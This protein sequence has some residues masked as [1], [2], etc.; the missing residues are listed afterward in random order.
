[1]DALPGSIR[2]GSALSRGTHD[3]AGPW[4]CVAASLTPSDPRARRRERWA[5]RRRAPGHAAAMGAADTALQRLRVAARAPEAAA[6]ARRPLA[7]PR[8]RRRGPGHPRWPTSDSTDSGPCRACRLLLRVGRRAT[9]LRTIGPWV[10]VL[11]GGGL[12]SAPAHVRPSRA[13]GGAGGVCRAR[14]WLWKRLGREGGGTPAVCPIPLESRHGGA[15]VIRDGRTDLAEDGQDQGHI[16]GREPVRAA[17]CTEEAVA[18]ASAAC[19]D[20]V[21][22]AAFAHVTHPAGACGD[23]EGPNLDRWGSCGTPLNV[24]KRSPMS[25]DSGRAVLPVWPIPGAV[26]WSACGAMWPRRGSYDPM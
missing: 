15:L 8:P 6:E 9:A 10:F 3:T 22:H 14:A 12:A 24:G 25:S 16:L 7:C 23:G 2:A 21:A 18:G 1:V 19:V 26:N 4:P 13:A 20:F 11:A 5:A 17:L